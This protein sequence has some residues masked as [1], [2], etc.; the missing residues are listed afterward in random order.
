MGEPQVQAAGR[1]FSH[2][3]WLLPAGR[4]GLSDLGWVDVAAPVAPQR[5]SASS[6]TGAGVRPG[7]PVKPGAAGG[8]AVAA[9]AA[10]AAA[11]ATGDCEVTALDTPC[12]RACVRA[13]VAA[14]RKLEG[15]MAG[16]VGGHRA[17]VA[18]WVEHERRWAGT[19]TKMVDELDT[20]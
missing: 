18:A 11:A 1:P 19:W 6:D 16:V 12:H 15:H 20:I 8:S 2:G 14:V 17:R 10:A 9:A 13:Y 5:A 3:T 4:L 7:S